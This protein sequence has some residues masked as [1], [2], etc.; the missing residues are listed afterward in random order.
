M[1]VFRSV[2]ASM[3]AV[4]FAENL[5]F[6]R[7]L[8]TSALAAA[9]KKKGALAGYSLSVIF[10]TAMA[11]VLSWV[12]EYFFGDD[13]NYRYYQPVFYICIIS[14]LYF[15]MLFAMWKLKGD[16]FRQIRNYLHI[17]AFNCAV[18]GVMLL[19]SDICNSFAEYLVYG[20]LSGI[21]YA[22]AVFM[23]SAVCDRIYSDKAPR[24]FRGFP[25]LL[26]YIGILSMAFFV[27]TG[28]TLT[29]SY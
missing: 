24:S 22:F 13:A 5:I 19:T 1:A 27:L 18:M 12:T 2:I 15:V 14:V 3:I 25:L 21:G 7:G 29:F 8:G 11:N 26:I 20:L 23:V 4:I 16:R 10:M 9:A 17:S 6:G 28:H